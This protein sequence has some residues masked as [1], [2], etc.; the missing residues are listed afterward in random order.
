M[1]VSSSHTT[2]VPTTTELTAHASA[3]DH[4]TARNMAYV[5]AALEVCSGDAIRKQRRLLNGLSDAEFWARWFSCVRCNSRFESLRRQLAE[6]AAELDATA[7][8]GNSRLPVAPSPN[9]E[10]VAL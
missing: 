2:S 5:F 4:E 3:E 10:E 7:S 8:A 1:G 6:R 9:A